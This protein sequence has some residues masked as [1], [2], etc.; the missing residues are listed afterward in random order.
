MKKIL[1]YS[2]CF[3]IT[4]L[5]TS[6]ETFAQKNFIE[7]YIITLKKDTVKGTIDYREW[8][9]NPSS[10]H[11]I[12]ATGKKSTFKPDDISGFYVPPKDLYISSHVSIDLSSIEPKDLIEHKDPKIV[13]DTA[14]FLLTVVKGKASLYYMKDHNNREHYYVS[15][16]GNPLIELLIKKNYMDNYDGNTMNHNYL[17]TVELF[18]GQLILLFDDCPSL[19]RNINNS[20]YLYS[21]IRSLVIKYN[22]CQHSSIDFVKKEEPIKFKFGVKSFVS[23][24]CNCR[25]MSAK[26]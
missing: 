15:K 9:L 10:I 5:F 12:D 20:E 2:L 22:E 4:I 7:G 8:N 21:S 23:V 6:N 13:K 24:R 17:A 3:F 18:K 11:F 16:D 25:I 19:K 1:F 26:V 14:L